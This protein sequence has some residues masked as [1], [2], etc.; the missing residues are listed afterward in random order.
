MKRKYNKSNTGNPSSLKRAASQPHFIPT[1]NK[2]IAEI[3]HPSS[4]IQPPKYNSTR[5]IRVQL[6]E[7]FNIPKFIDF[8]LFSHNQ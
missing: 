7:Y 3:N 2:T 1:I 5:P 4:R 6:P 8:D